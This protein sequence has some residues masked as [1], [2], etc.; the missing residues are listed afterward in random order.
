M[1]KA[2]KR[3]R[4]TTK[5][6]KIVIITIVSVGILVGLAAGAFFLV[7]K[8][9]QVTA[10]ATVDQLYEKV[11]AYDYSNGHSEEIESDIKRLL[12]ETQLEETT[13]NYAK[14]LKAKAEYY[15]GLQKYYA[16]VTAFKE[17]EDYVLNG[18]DLIYLSKHLADAYEKFGNSELATK[19]QEQYDMLTRKCGVDSN[20]EEEGGQDEN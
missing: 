20:S 7:K 8:L 16:A 5:V 6:V 12:N 2:Q 18:D 3:N 14:T 11:Q 13:D 17:L 4:K 1:S 9:N 10:P 19:Y 15:Y